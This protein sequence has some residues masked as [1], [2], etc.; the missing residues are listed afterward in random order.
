MSQQG[1]VDDAEDAG[2]VGSHDAQLDDAGSLA[3]SEPRQIPGELEAD[4][5]GPSCCEPRSPQV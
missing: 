2:G 5:N 4:V 1:K 3:V